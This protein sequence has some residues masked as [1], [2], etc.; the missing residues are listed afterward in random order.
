[1]NIRYIEPYSQTKVSIIVTN[2]NSSL[3]VELKDDTKRTSYEAIGLATY[4]N[5]KP[6]VLSYISIFESLWKQAEL[7]KQLIQAYE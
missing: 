7:Y 5:S 3:S 6:T 1:M 4:S 2:N